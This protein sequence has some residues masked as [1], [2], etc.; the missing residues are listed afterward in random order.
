[1]E[2]HHYG[3]KENITGPDIL[4]NP[5]TARKADSRQNSGFGDRKQIFGKTGTASAFKLKK[6][7]GI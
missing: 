2:D 1:M 4:T 5:L 6:Q 3:Q 7:N